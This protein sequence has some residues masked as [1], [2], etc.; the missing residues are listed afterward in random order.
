VDSLDGMEKKSR[1]W[2]RKR[3]VTMRR[4]EAELDSNADEEGEEEDGGC[5]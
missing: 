3:K 1:R 2:A 5:R 4:K